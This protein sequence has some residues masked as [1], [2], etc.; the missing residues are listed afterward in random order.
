M[1]KA[2]AAKKAFRGGA[3]RGAQGKGTLLSGIGPFVADER[4]GPFAAI[5]LVILHVVNTFVAKNG[6]LQ[7]PLG[8]AAVF[9]VPGYLW[10]DVLSGK[11]RISEISE[12]VVTSIALSIG[13]VILVMTVSSLL[14]HVPVTQGNTVIALSAV[15]LAGIGARVVF[16]RKRIL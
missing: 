1:A 9:L 8:L 13:L 10:L 7:V 11:L 3:K 15:S 6:V 16:L 4:F 14:L 12:R 5:L 2:A